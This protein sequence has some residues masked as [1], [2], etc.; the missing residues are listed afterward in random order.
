LSR[1]CGSTFRTFFEGLPDV[2]EFCPILRPTI[3]GALALATARRVAREL[4]HVLAAAKQRWKA[5]P[6]AWVRKM[7]ELQARRAAE[8]KK[9]R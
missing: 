7:R 9:L 8:L 1:G 6:N 5:D 3:E 2:R 4:G